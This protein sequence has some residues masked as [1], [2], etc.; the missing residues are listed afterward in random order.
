MPQHFAFDGADWGH[1][2][3]YDQSTEHHDYDQNY[4]YED[5]EHFA[6]EEPNNDASQ[7]GFDDVDMHQQS[8][9]SE[10][11]IVNTELHLLQGESSSSAYSTA[12]TGEAAESSDS[13][14]M[15]KILKIA[16]NDNS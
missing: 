2:T 12:D 14:I 5:V 15:L 1:H 10:Y 6:Y 9:K 16:L 8:G 3:E 4:N 11:E 7:Y 13:P